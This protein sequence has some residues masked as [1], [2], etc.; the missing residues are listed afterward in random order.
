M[1]TSFECMFRVRPRVVLL[2]GEDTELNPDVLF[3]WLKDAAAASGRLREERRGV[4][5]ARRKA[6][7]NSFAVEIYVCEEDKFYGQDVCLGVGRRCLCMA[8]D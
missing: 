7:A 8:R 5:R 2:K 3:F 6:E 1:M 4:R